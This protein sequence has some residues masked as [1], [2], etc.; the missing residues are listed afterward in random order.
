MLKK[1]IKVSDV[2]I[3]ICEDSHMRSIKSKIDKLIADES[4]GKRR[5]DIINHDVFLIN[6]HANAHSPHYSHTVGQ[7]LL[8]LSDRTKL[9]PSMLPR[10]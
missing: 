7:E 10:I 3:I 1:Y 4:P 5:I 2:L 8:F 9:K 6:L